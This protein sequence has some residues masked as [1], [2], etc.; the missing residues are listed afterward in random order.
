MTLFRCLF[1]SGLL[2]AGVLFAK[3]LAAA[4]KITYALFSMTFPPYQYLKNGQY[5]G[6][7][8]DQVIE[9]FKR[10]PEYELDLVVMPIRRAMLYSEQGNIDMLMT[11]R[12]KY[13]ETFSLYTD[14]AL[15]RNTFRPVVLKG[16]SFPVNS[17]ENLYGGEY[18]TLNFSPLNPDILR[19]E[20]DGN[21]GIHR[22]G[23]Y[24]TLINMLK[25]RRLKA[26][27][28]SYS[29]LLGEAQRMGVEVEAIDYEISAPRGVYPSISLNSDVSDKERLRDRFNWALQEIHRD[30]TFDKIM[31]KYG[32]T[33]TAEQSP[34]IKDETTLIEDAAPDTDL[35]RTK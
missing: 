35:F 21:I 7:D 9:A 13:Y 3:T 20:K 16:D 6:P 5:Y 8:K 24:T 34:L 1:L 17:V 2:V 28:S 19:A 15:H 14:I 22:A 32:V 31:S 30:G 4:E 10:L 26:V 25:K 27:F 12:F 23:S 18:G 33:L 29:A 11:Y